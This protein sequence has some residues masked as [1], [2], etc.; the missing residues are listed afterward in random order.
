MLDLLAPLRPTAKRMFGGVA[1]MLNGTMF[2]L[3]TRDE[4]YFRVDDTSR[5]R[6]EAAGCT[7][8]GYS[9]AGRDVVIASYYAVPPDLYDQ[10]EELLTWA[11][12]AAAAAQRSAKRRKPRRQ[13]SRQRAS[14][15]GA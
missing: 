1:I 10:P 4:L 5:G 9:R 7:P 13:S 14:L 11:R 2:A 6:F 8:F 3:L 15:R 12:R